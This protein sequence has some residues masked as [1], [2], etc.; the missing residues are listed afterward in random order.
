MEQRQNG[1]N[2]LMVSR[3]YLVDLEALA[4]HVVMGDH[5]LHASLVYC[6]ARGQT[7]AHSLRKTSRPAAKAQKPAEILVCLTGG[8]LEWW[9]LSTGAQALTEAREVFDSSEAFPLA[10]EKNDTVLR[11]SSISCG[12]DGD[13][14]RGFRCHQD[15]GMGGSQGVCHF[16][17]VVSGRGTGDHSTL[18]QNLAF[19]CQKNGEEDEDRGR[20]E[21]H[22][23][24]VRSKHGH[25]IPHCVGTEK[26]H[27]LSRAEA[28]FLRQGCRDICCVALQLLIRDALIGHGVP[29]TRSFIRRRGRS[30]EPVPYRQVL[31]Y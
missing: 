4:N 5:D 24:T 28:E 19:G 18:I 16:L 15:F 27:C 17:H 6:V 8:N 20:R 9:R 11:D 31:R 30:K 1:K 2:S 3:G 13:R 7:S 21:M 14:K 29:E 25:W 22:T 12:G 23:D 26:R 10:F